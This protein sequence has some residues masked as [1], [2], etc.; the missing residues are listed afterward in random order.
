[1]TICDR[2][3]AKN[4]QRK[5]DVSGHIAKDVRPFDLCE[6]CWR[7]LLSLIERFLKKEIQ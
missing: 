5:V 3:S 7:R 6:D 4:P 1:M 2:C